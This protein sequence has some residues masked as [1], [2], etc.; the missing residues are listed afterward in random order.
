[1]AFQFPRFFVLSHSLLG[2]ASLPSSTDY[3]VIR[4]SIGQY[5]ITFLDT[6]NDDNFAKVKYSVSV[7]QKGRSIGNV[8]SPA[9]MELYVKNK[10]N[11][12]FDIENI[13][14]EPS[15]DGDNDTFR[16]A[17][18]IDFACFRGMIC[19]CQGSFTGGQPIPVGKL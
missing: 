7:S 4:N 11:L 13:E 14:R 10:T 17:A 18:V 9:R 6:W 3:N 19:F 12:Q 2:V 5:T 15:I 16:D 8:S 1:M